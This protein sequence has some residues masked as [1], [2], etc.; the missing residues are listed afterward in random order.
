MQWSSKNN[1]NLCLNSVIPTDFLSSKGKLLYNLMPILLTVFFKFITHLMWWCWNNGG[2]MIGGGKPKKHR[3]RL[4]ELCS[5]H[6]MLHMNL[7]R[8][9]SKALSYGMAVLCS[10]ISWNTNIS[11]VSFIST[12]VVSAD[13]LCGLVVRVL[14]Y[15][16]GGPGSIPGTTKKKKSSGSGTGSTQPREYNW[17]A[18]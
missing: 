9:K 12:F 18:T 10:Y 6:H 2:M 13:R 11:Q 16:S 8:I 3:E 15:R 7:P 5:N 1:F 4:T 17:G 14:G